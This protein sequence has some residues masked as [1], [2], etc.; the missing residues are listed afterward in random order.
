MLE[1][2]LE[3]SVSLLC[4]DSCDRGAWGSDITP[5]LLLLL[6]SWLPIK[7]MLVEAEL[8][9]FDIQALCLDD[10]DIIF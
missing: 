2:F 7:L 5:A 6:L 4:T 1:F 3:I 10:N 9:V 8:D